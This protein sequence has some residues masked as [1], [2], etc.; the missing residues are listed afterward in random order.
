MP[1]IPYARP[2]PPTASGIALRHRFLQHSRP[3][4]SVSD[5]QGWSNFNDNGGVSGGGEV[6]DRTSDSSAEDFGLREM[7]VAVVELEATLESANADSSC[8]E[9]V[10]RC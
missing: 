8:V 10:L 6:S 2:S 1:V 3:A 9:S 5:G 4:L 7:G